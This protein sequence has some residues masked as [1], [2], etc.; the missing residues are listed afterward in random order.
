MGTASDWM[1]AAFWG[2]FWAGGMLLF[3][4]LSRS[5]KHIKPVLSFW[6]VL[7]W[8][9]TGMGCGLGT[10]FRWGARLES[11]ES[12]GPAFPEVLKTTTKFRAAE[13]NDGVGAVNGPVHSGTFE[14]RADGHLAAGLHNTSGSAQTLSVE[15]RVA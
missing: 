1:S 8:A 13:S 7:G 5:D 11:D 6:D 14:S 10:T 12:C 2:M 3:E 4:V 15:L 9:F